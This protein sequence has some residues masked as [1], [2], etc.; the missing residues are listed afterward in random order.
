MIYLRRNYKSVPVKYVTAIEEAGLVVS[1][2]HAIALYTCKSGPNRGETGPQGPAGAPYL[3]DT[4]I[5]SASPE[6]AALSVDLVTPATHFRA[7]FAINISYVR[8]SLSVAPT[9]APVIVDVFMNGVTIFSTPIQIDIGS[10]TSVGSAVPA[11][12]SVTEVPDDA[13][14]TVFITQV[15]SA[16]TGSGVKVALTGTKVVA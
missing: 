7:P 8:V 10:K 15:G 13:E 3:Y 1:G 2:K 12:L 5:A 4:I 16:V 6:Y 11:V 14:F 9:G